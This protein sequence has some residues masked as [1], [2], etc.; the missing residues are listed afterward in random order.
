MPLH[1]CQL[2]SPTDTIKG[3][4]ERDAR[5]SLMSVGLKKALNS[6]MLSGMSEFPTYLLFV[7]FSFLENVANMLCNGSSS[8]TK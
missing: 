7:Q 8:F 6:T 2:S 4:Q 1:S 5:L 3:I